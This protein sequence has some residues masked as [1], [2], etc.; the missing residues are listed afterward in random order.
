M[1]A[2]A[3]LERELAAAAALARDPRCA[4][5]L[6]HLRIDE[7]TWGLGYVEIHGQLYEPTETGEP[8]FIVSHEIGSELLDLVCCRLADRFMASRLGQ[9]G[10]LGE[11]WIIV[12]RR[13][14]V[15]LPLFHDAL[16][17]AHGGFVG[18]TVVDWKQARSAL[19]GAP[20]I[21]CASA[22][23]AQRVHD[24]FTVPVDLP[25]LAYVRKAA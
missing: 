19:S 8:A 9:A 24:A 3:D 12:A 14:G 5:A 23:L 13:Y 10:V 11:G 16:Q 2:A 1:M 18:A 17:W 20:S 7:A 6:A 21:T 4:G 22:Q 25:A 15:A